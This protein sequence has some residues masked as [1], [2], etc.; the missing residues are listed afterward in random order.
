MAVTHLGRRQPVLTTLTHPHP[1][2]PS[3]PRRFSPDCPGPLNTI[4]TCQPRSCRTCTTL[5][6]PTPP[7]DP[8]S[9]SRPARP[10]Y[11]VQHLPDPTALPIAP[12]LRPSATVPS[13]PDCPPQPVPIDIDLPV[14]PFSARPIATHHC[15]T[16]R[17]RHASPALTRLNRPALGTSDTPIPRP[18]EP[19]PTTP[20]QPARDNPDRTRQP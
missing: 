9:H 14:Q 5:L 12:R 18:S 1:T 7:D 3:E 11:P 8:T 20:A 17:S 16:H 10:D 6:T 19:T 2:S 15:C 4:P 13:K